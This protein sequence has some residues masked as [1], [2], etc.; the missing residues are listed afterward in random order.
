[1]HL[2]AIFEAWIII[3]PN[4]IEWVKE[5]VKKFPQRHTIMME[6]SL[7]F[8]LTP[9]P[10]NQAFIIKKV[11]FRAPWPPLRPR[12]WAGWACCRGL[13]SARGPHVTGTDGGFLRVARGAVPGLP[14]L[15]SSHFQCCVTSPWVPFQFLCKSSSYSVLMEESESQLSPI[16]LPK[17][18]TDKI[19]KCTNTDV[20]RNKHPCMNRYICIGIQTYI[21]ICIDTHMCAN[22][23]VHKHV[24]THMYQYRHIRTWRHTIYTFIDT[25]PYSHLY[26]YI[27]MHKYVET[28]CNTQ[29]L[30]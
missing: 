27:F 3:I 28:N 13:R 14:I 2:S 24:W 20:Y 10:P 25:H 16:Q 15:W 11:P 18:L 21:L 23:H 12:P 17:F 5:K 26:N 19:H 7:F 6:E 22:I 1:M 9:L 29:N 8:F 4:K 30:A